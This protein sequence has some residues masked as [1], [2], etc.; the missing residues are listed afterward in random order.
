MAIDRVSFFTA[1]RNDPFGGKLTQPQVDGINILLAEWDKRHLTDLRWLAY[2][3]GTTMWETAYTMQP[4]AE[5]GH[6]TGHSYGHPDPETGQTYYGRGYVQLTWKSNYQKFAALLGVDLVGHPDLAMD[7]RIAVQII[8]EGM[9]HGL[10]TGMGLATPF[11]NNKTDWI[12]ARAIVNGHDRA[13]DIAAISMAFY[14]ALM[15]S[16]GGTA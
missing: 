1:V 2:I 12:E 10:F 9:I 7:P 13:E 5:Y 11:S 3:L 4:V 14:S 15:A 8:Y 6:G 16:T